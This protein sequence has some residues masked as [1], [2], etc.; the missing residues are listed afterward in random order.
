VIEPTEV[1]TGTVSCACSKDEDPAEHLMLFIDTDDFMDGVEIDAVSWFKELFAEHMLEHFEIRFG[2][3]VREVQELCGDTIWLRQLN[4]WF[5]CKLPK[6]H[7][8]R[9]ESTI[10]WAVDPPFDDIPEKRKV[11]K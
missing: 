9:H 1:V 8:G 4:V 5:K 3:E 10:Q 7:D 11:V 6:G 2:P